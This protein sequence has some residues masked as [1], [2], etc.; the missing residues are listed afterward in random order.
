MIRYMEVF[1]GGYKYDAKEFFTITLP[2]TIRNAE[3]FRF[4]VDGAC[5]MGWTTE[6]LI[7]DATESNLKQD[8]FVELANL[9]TQRCTSFDSKITGRPLKLDNYRMLIFSR[10]FYLIEG[11]FYFFNNKWRKNISLLYKINRVCNKRT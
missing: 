1:F 4:F 6:N 7:I 8:I 9:K 10:N 2:N 3:G 5:N 11:Q